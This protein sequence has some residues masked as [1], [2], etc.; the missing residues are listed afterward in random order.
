LVV[1]SLLEG[2]LRIMPPGLAPAAHPT[3]LESGFTQGL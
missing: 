3:G 1:L 2:F